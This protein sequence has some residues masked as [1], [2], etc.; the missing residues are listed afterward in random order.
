MS[1]GPA[2]LS[3]IEVA[4]GKLSTVFASK[5]CTVALGDEVLPAS[6][7]DPSQNQTICKQA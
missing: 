5:A 3:L 1:D 4:L 6:Y 2:E 7:W